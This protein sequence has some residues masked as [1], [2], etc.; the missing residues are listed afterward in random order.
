M[1]ESSFEDTDYNCLLVD[2]FKESKQK[3]KDDYEVFED[4]LEAGREYFLSSLKR[5]LPD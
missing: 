3:G 2:K 4:T 1:S 5:V